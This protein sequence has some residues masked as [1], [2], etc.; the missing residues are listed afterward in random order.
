[1]AKRIPS[2]LARRQGKK[3]ARQSLLM[4]LLAIAGSLIFLFIIVPQIVQLFF[5][6]FGSGD[7]N[8]NPEDTIPP[9]VPVISPPP[10][11]TKESSVVLDGFGEAKSLVVVVI[12][13]R[14]IDR[15]IVDDKGQFSY[16]L[17]LDEGENLVSLYGVDQADNESASKQYVII[18]DTKAPSLVFEDLNNDKQIT[19]RD[20]Q[21]FNIKGETEPDSQ[22]SLNE[23]NI[24]VRSDGTF[25]TQIYLQEGDNTLKFVVVDQAGNRTEQTIKVNFKY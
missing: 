2:R 25:T 23:R 4:I 17:K 19:G 9:Q 3:M 5:R 6:F 20:Q 22:L 15:A 16:T 18:R 8:F 21:N 1:M 7:L 13:G 10:E 12:N 14:E 11:A 24:Y